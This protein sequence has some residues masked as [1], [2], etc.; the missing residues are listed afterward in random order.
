MAIG[1]ADIGMWDVPRDELTLIH[2][3]ELVM[4]AAQ[5]GAFRG[6]L[7]SGGAGRWAE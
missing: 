7:S 2:Q 1:S 3:N 5:A 4:P 6:M